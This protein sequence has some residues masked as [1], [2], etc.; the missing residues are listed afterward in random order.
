MCRSCGL[1]ENDR[2]ELIFKAIA[3]VVLFAAL[4]AA[5]AMLRSYYLAVSVGVFLSLQQFAVVA[6]FASQQLRG[7]ALAEVFN[8]FSLLNFDIDFVK[9]GCTVG[10]I[11]HVQVFW[12]T[13]T[14]ILMAAVLFAAGSLLYACCRRSESKPCCSAFGF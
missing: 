14:I 1:E 13:L 10:R 4:S 3:A 8:V 2:L 7:S 12:G 11:S 9:A 5:V 6:R